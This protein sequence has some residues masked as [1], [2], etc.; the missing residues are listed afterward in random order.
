[1]SSEREASLN[2]FSWDPS[3][4]LDYGVAVEAAGCIDDVVHLQAWGG[5]QVGLDEISG[6][7]VFF[8]VSAVHS[9]VLLRIA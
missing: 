6:M 7:Q 4:A 1:M 8:A 2:P 5:P 9:A 3:L